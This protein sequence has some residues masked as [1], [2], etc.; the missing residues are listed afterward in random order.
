MLPS[1]PVTFVRAYALAT[2]IGLLS[3]AGAAQASAPEFAP[4]L[5]QSGEPEL[6][7]KSKVVSR[8]LFQLPVFAPCG[9]GITSC[10]KIPF[11]VPPKSRLEINHISCSFT[12]RAPGYVSSAI[13]GFLAKN[14]ATFDYHVPVKLGSD[15]SFQTF[16]FNGDT[17]VTGDA[18]KK[19]GVAVNATDDVSNM[20]CLVVGEL[21]K[22][23]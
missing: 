16:A 9:N 13:V 4:E 6:V 21:L 3:T 14:K 19:L 17:H 22:L 23:K 2:I 11:T 15:G 1:R 12:L 5:A 7:D 8:A 10:Y 18:G 20:N